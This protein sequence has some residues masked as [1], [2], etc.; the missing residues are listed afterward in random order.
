MPRLPPMHVYGVA[1]AEFTAAVVE[2][3]QGEFRPSY[4]MD[5]LLADP[6]VAAGFRYRV[7]QKLPRLSRDCPSYR[8]GQELLRVRKAGLLPPRHCEP[9]LP[10]LN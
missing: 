3:F 5:E 6:E 2:V 1:D 9:G 4:S 10:G 8:F 7:R